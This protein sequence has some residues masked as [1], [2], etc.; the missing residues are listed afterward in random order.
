MSKA[1]TEEHVREVAEFMER[2][3]EILEV[4]SASII[5]TSRL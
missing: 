2:K 5:K 3:Q 4:E 1:E